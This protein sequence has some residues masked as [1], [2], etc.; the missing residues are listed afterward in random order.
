MQAAVAGAAGGVEDGDLPVRAQDRAVHQR[1]AQQG[2]GVPQEVAGGEVV[3]PVDHHVP[4]AQHLRG[5]GAGQAQREGED[6]DIGVERGEGL[7]GR[8][9]LGAPDVGGAV[10][11][12]PLEVRDLDRIRVDDPQPPHT[13]GRQV[14]GGRRAEP[15]GADDEDAG[16]PDPLLTGRADLRDEDV[17]V[18]TASLGGGQGATALIGD[19]A[20][21]GLTHGRPPGS[22]RDGPGSAPGRP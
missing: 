3:R 17:T 8:V 2:A 5:V 12:L 13:G 4:A 15:P 10:E 16:R 6:L 11:D 7:A 9:G 19:H 22:Q 20:G 1:D 21:D 18:V 14:E